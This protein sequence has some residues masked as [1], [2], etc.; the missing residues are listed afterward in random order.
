MDEGLSCHP[1]LSPS[2]L[3]Q[4]SQLT[5]QR[6]VVPEPSASSLAPMYSAECDFLFSFS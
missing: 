1:P 6:T 3:H 2:S 4:L 5:F